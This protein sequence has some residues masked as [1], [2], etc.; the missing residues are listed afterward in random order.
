MVRLFDWAKFVGAAKAIG[1][2]SSSNC[3][4][5]DRVYMNGNH[6]CYDRG[7]RMVYYKKISINQPTI[8]IWLDSNSK[9]V[10][11]EALLSGFGDKN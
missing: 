3:G 4:F 10:W 6:I 5:V 2:N 1:A 9:A 11:M 8:N 7:E